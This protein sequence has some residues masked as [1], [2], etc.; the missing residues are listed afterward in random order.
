L[1]R[2]IR[3]CSSGQFY[4]AM[5]LRL[6]AYMAFHSPSRAIIFLDGIRASRLDVNS[7]YEVSK[8]MQKLFNLIER[9]TI[10]RCTVIHHNKINSHLRGAL[11]TELS[12]TCAPAFPLT[13]NE[14][15]GA[16]T[17]TV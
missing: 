5:R 17:Y 3:F 12:T 10:H 11:G 1:P 2:N 16:V 9:T 8:L 7:N 15:S 4:T 14:A 13:T 6:L